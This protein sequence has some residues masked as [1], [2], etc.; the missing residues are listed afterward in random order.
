MTNLIKDLVFKEGGI[1]N[2]VSAK[3]KDLFTL[4]V[5]KES[6]LGE[7]VYTIYVKNVKDE[8]KWCNLGPAFI[9]EER[10]QYII[11]NLLITSFKNKT[12]KK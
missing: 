5:V 4:E 7:D 11:K 2:K 12:I 9:D 6:V 8:S 1:F 10:A 3:P